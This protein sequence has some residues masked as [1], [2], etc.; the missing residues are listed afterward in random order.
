MQ[1]EALEGER[2][3]VVEGLRYVHYQLGGKYGEGAGSI[4]IPLG[5]VLP[6]RN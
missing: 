5:V 4:V 3:E 6:R 1:G 2:G